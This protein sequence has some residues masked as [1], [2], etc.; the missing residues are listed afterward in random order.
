LCLE[1]K[2][3][4]NVGRNIHRTVYASRDVLILPTTKSEA[5]IQSAQSGIEE[6]DKGGK[7]EL[8]CEELDDP[9]KPEG[10]GVLYY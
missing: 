3:L 10:A 7:T 5:G 1:N 4:E 6:G 2:I 8:M 9:H